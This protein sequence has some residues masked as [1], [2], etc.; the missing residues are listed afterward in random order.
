MGSLYFHEKWYNVKQLNHQ[1]IDALLFLDQ[2]HIFVNDLN[3]R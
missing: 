1:D 2:A 3:I